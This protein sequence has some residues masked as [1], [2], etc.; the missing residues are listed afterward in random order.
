MGIVCGQTG[1]LS[2]SF[3]IWRRTKEAPP[4]NFSS[5]IKKT[6]QKMKHPAC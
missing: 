3:F 4:L 2:I 1:D 5:K 6:Q